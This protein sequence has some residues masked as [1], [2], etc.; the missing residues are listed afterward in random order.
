MEGGGGGLTFAGF[1]SWSIVH[2]GRLQLVK[3]LVYVCLA[4]FGMMPAKAL[5]EREVIQDIFRR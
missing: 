2:A 5:Q 4:E 1:M 3:D